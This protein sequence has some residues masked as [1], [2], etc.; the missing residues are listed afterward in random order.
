MA[1]LS[2]VVYKHAVTGE[3]M[4]QVL[5]NGFCEMERES[6]F[7]GYCI[8]SAFLDS[9]VEMCVITHEQREG[10]INR[11]KKVLDIE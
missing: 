2:V 9:L 4:I 1:T 11:L 8:V 6:D 3:D 10:K 5:V 7:N